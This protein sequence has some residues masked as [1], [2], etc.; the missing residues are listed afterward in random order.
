MVKR[1]IALY[2]AYRGGEWFEASLEP[3]S[4]VCD[5]AVIVFA[6]GPW[7]ASS[8]LPENCREPVERFQARKPGLRIE[9]IGGAWTRQEDQYDAGMAA[10]RHHF[11]SESGV[12]IVDT[13]EVWTVGDLGALKK[14][15]FAHPRQ[16]TFYAQIKTYL[17]SPLY[18][19]WPLEG[20]CLVAIQDATVPCTE[21]RFMGAPGPS[22]HL[23]GIDFH[24]FPYVRDDEQDIREKFANTSSQERQASRAEWLDEVW[25]NLPEGENLHMTPGCE[26]AWGRIKIL[27]PASIPPGIWANDFVQHA[28][29]REDER[30]ARR[31]R[32]VPPERA[33]CPQPEWDLGRGTDFER[34]FGGEDI[35]S[36]YAKMQTTCLEALWLRHWASEVPPGGR[37]AEIGCGHGVSTAC[38]AKASPEGVLIDAIDPFEPYTET[39][40]TTVENV[41]EGDEA[42][43]WATL[44]EHA[45][46]RKVRHLKVS[47]ADAAP[48]LGPGEYDLFSIDGNHTEEWVKQDLTL[49]WQFTKPGGLVILH[50]FSTRFPGVIR[51]VDAFAESQSIPVTVAAGTSFAYLRKPS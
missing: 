41:V 38:L 39:A 35:C 32:E 18:Q 21:G 6:E 20:L 8:S 33:I 19:V 45:C 1:F 10:I 24:H 7:D 26:S 43:F 25:P 9:A 48:H 46:S 15:V 49:A 44:D 12:L 36:L 50:D 29:R 27:T 28:A 3:V 16:R 51:A 4:Q 42:D 37:I 31:I 13:D 5:G 47:S 34:Y 2:K 11:G 30:W 23:S 14:A 40:L 17:R 22:L